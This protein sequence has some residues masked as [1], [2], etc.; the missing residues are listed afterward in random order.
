MILIYPE[1]GFQGHRSLPSSIDRN[2]AK[3]T[4]QSAYFMNR[5]ATVYASLC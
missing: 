4:A 5:D 2:R 1:P 3:Y